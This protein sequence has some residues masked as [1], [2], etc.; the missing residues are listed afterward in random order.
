[1]AALEV[2]L[3]KKRILD[4]T[5]TGQGSS[6]QKTLNSLI[7]SSINTSADKILQNPWRGAEAWHFFLM[8]QR[9]LYK[10]EY[11]YALKTSLRLQEYELDLDPRYPQFLPM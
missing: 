11:K 9:Q 5:M 4:A 2:D 7:T 6:T 10:G 8:A 3:Y 1:M